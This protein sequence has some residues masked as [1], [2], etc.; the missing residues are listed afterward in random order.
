MIIAVT[1]QRNWNQR[2]PLASSGQ[3]QIPFFPM[4]LHDAVAIG[5]FTALRDRIA[6]GD[7]DERDGRGRTP[8]MWACQFGHLECAEALIEAGA[9]VDIVDN[10]GGVW[11]WLRCRRWRGTSL[12]GC[13][14]STCRA[15]VSRTSWQTGDVSGL[16]APPPC[17]SSATGLPRLTNDHLDFYTHQQAQYMTA[18]ATCS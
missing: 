6:Q 18:Q 10:A 15:R 13:R 5:D 2:K 14:S 3:E 9:A 17:A 12:R 7:V 4:S 11:V 1:P 16:M 8:L